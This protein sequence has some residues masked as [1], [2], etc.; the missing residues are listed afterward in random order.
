MIEKFYPLEEMIKSGNIAFFVGSGISFDPPLN[1]PSWNTIAEAA[2]SSICYGVL[3]DELQE[4]KVRAKI[5]RPEILLEFMYGIIKDKAI[6]VLDVLKVEKSNLNHDFL[7]YLFLN[8]NVPIITTNYDEIIEFTTKHIYGQDIWDKDYYDKRGFSKWLNSDRKE[9]GLFKLHGTIRYPDSIKAA[10]SQVISGTSKEMYDLLSYFFQNY[11]I[12]FWGYSLTNDFDIVPHLLLNI[13]PKSI[14]WLKYGKEILIPEQR[15][16]I[17]EKLKFFKERLDEYFYKLI[18]GDLSFKERENIQEERYKYQSLI[19]YIELFLR[20]E[21]FRIEYLTTQFPKM[22][23]KDLLKEGSNTRVNN[24]FEKWSSDIN[25]WDRILIGAE[26]YFYLREIERPWQKLINL[27]ERAIQLPQKRDR[28]IIENLARAYF[29]KGWGHRL[30]GKELLFRI[31][32]SQKFSNF[33]ENLNNLRE[34]FERNGFSL[35]ESIKIE[36]ENEK[37]LKVFDNET[38]YIIEKEDDVIK[39]SKDH[40]NPSL[41]SFNQYGYNNTFYQILFLE[42]LL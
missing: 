17:S 32:C 38:I 20:A 35:S 12:I 4:L 28:K 15:K 10:L 29:L 16:T 23:W 37:K 40:Y 41:K 39:V 5:I 6:N 27:C 26:I 11:T 25:D 31:E 22:L 3:K 30:I 33:L 8:Y 14:I 2:I 13:K 9:N 19:N 34:I 1:L 36:K 7:A 42:E 21:N 24:F 18:K